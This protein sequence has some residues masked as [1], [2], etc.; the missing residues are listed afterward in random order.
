MDELQRDNLES[1][2]FEDKIKENQEKIT[3]YLILLGM[4]SNFGRSLFGFDQV[5][6]VTSQQHLQ[7]LSVLEDGRG[8][9]IIFVELNFLYSVLLYV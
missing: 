9:K 4:P 5:T 3:G 7:V 6:F 1:K 8:R 2:Y